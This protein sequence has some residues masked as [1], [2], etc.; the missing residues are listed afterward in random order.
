MERRQSEGCA[1]AILIAN[2][3]D[4]ADVIVIN[5]ATKFAK[6][7]PPDKQEL[8]LRPI[9]STT[10]ETPGVSAGITRLNHISAEAK[11][12]HHVAAP[13]SKAVDA[14]AC[15]K[16]SKLSQSPT[17]SRCIVVTPRAQIPSD[18]LG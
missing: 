13:Y 4:T 9:A 18:L 12:R 6:K 2:L 7:I 15:R 1:R 11:L 8:C 17:V 5:T 14:A 10:E 3:K 16:N